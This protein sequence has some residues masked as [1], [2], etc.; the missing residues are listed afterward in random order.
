MKELA[1]QGLGWAIIFLISMTPLVFIAHLVA[2]YLFHVDW[3]LDWYDL[4]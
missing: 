3:S 2:L 1:V 4:P